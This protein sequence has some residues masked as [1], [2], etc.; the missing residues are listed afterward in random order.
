MLRGYKYIFND[1]HMQLYH[2]LDF[3]TIVN[4]VKYITRQ[5]F[6]MAFV[7]QGSMNAGQYFRPG[8]VS[9]ELTINNTRL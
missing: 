8:E 5:F 1:T 4:S 6:V 7:L 2:L 9:I 3:G